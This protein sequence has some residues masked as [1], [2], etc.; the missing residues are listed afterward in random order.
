MFGASN[1]LCKVNI[2]LMTSFKL[3]ERD[4]AIKGSSVSPVLKIINIDSRTSD[5]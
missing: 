5:M 4:L 1:A 2:Q 3:K